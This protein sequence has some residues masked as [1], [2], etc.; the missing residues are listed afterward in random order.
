M[1]ANAGVLKVA[2]ILDSKITRLSP[3]SVKLITTILATV[4]DMSKLFSVNV[5][6][7]FLCYKY[8]ARQMIAQ[9]RGGRIIGENYTSMQVMVR[10]LMDGNIPKVHLL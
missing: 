1:V 10:S 7:V 2:G 9:G 4:D 6:G 8:A 5:T 3:L